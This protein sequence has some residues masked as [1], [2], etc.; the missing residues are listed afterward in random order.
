MGTAELGMR[1]GFNKALAPVFL[2]GPD[3]GVAE[4][5]KVERVF[6]G[7]WS[8]RGLRRPISSP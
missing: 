8:R 2:V 7:G 3:M 5:P 1:N 4:A 6:A